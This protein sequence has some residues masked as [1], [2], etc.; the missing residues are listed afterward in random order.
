MSDTA[1]MLALANN[2]R[3]DGFGGNNSSM[4]WI[5]ILFFLVGGNG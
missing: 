5:L 3:D 2:I 1:D 4:W